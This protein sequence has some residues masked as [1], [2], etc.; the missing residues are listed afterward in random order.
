[1]WRGADILQP[2]GNFKAKVSA[3]AFSR[4]YLLAVALVAHFSDGAM[5]M[6]GGWPQDEEL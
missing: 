6:I 4:L 1:M 5:R 2:R 3:P